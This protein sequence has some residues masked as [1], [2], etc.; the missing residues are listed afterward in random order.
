M[1]LTP[2]QINTLTYTTT[3][4]EYQANVICVSALGIPMPLGHFWT[5]NYLTN[6]QVPI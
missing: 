1:A 6:F 3:Y 4:P 2:Y 5:L